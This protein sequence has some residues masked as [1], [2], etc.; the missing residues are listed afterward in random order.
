VRRFCRY[1][2][3]MGTIDAPDYVVGEVIKKFGGLDG[4]VSNAGINQ[5][6]PLVHYSVADWDRIFAVNTRATWLLAKAGYPALKESHGAIVAVA[7]MS[8]TSPMQTSARMG[9]VRRP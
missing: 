8:G 9:R 4:L 3:D 2:G 5:P 1:N 6:G 7:S